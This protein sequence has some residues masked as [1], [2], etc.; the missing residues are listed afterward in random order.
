M[1]YKNI[2]EISEKKVINIATALH[3]CNKKEHILTYINKINKTI[4]L[5]KRV[6]EKNMNTDNE[7]I[8]EIE[9]NLALIQN[10][11]EQ[12]R[13]KLQIIKTGK[14]T[15][16]NKIN[17][18]KWINIESIDENRITSGI[19]INN[20]IEDL[21]RFFKMCYKIFE[22]KINLVSRGN[23]LQI[24]TTFSGIF[25]KSIPPEST[26]KSFISAKNFIDANTNL[27]EWYEEN[28]KN[29]FVSTLEQLQKDEMGSLMQ[30]L[31]LK[32]DVN[33]IEIKVECEFPPLDPLKFIG[34]YKF[35]R[36]TESNGDYCEFCHMVASLYHAYHMIYSN[37]CNVEM[38]GERKE[39]DSVIN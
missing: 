16:P 3:Q 26:I 37:P 29:I 33:K 7:E 13:R 31:H 12:F 34:D 5:L 10:Y 39:N 1:D 4:R 35:V 38:D 19:I 30:I 32:L 11:K 9:K 8:L 23:I 24:N 27:L 28:I 2:L 25:F 36:N 20:G 6:I 18:L 15:N 21:N 14:L 22:D 17:K